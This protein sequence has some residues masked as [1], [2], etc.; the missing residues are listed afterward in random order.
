MTP[1]Q[2]LIRFFRPSPIEPQKLKTVEDRYAEMANDLFDMTPASAEQTVALRHL[3]DSK[4]AA[5][6]SLIEDE[7]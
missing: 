6:R 4:H 2:R 7:G 1:A 3:L 5:V